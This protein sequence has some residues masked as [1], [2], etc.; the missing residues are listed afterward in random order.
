MNLS[1]F[2]FVV[3]HREAFPFLTPAVENWILARHNNVIFSF[4]DAIHVGHHDVSRLNHPLLYSL[5]Y[6]SGIVEVLKRSTHIIAGNRSLADFAIRYN[7][8]VSIFP[9]VVDT[10]RYLYRPQREEDGRP[11]TIGWMG[12]RS[13][14]PYLAVIEPALKRISDTYRERVQFRFFGSPDYKLAVSNFKSF[15]FNVT[16]EISDLQSFDLGIMPL[17][18]T[19]WTRGKCAFKAIQYMAT[20]AVTVAS[21]VGMTTELV[22]DDVNGL[23]ASS[24]EDW[25][26]ALN[27]LLL[28]REL[29]QRLSINARKTI[30]NSYSLDVWGPRM[31][32]LFDQ[33]AD[34]PVQATG[35]KAY[36][37]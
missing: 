37:N 36:V 10:D 4:D 30:E 3:I 12:S 18:D 19:E 5:K 2:D 15:P 31:V 32:S 9:T 11:L 34:R 27:R 26:H 17:P 7:P 8:R 21:P 25:F 1:K 22:R 13:T 20:G 35:Q 23:L 6:G 14:V 29:R 16:T 33:L 24:S 28:D